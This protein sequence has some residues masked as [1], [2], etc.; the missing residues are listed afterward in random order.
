MTSFKQAQFGAWYGTEF[1]YFD[2]IAFK[3]DLEA[4]N[5]YTAA[6]N[7]FPLGYEYEYGYDSSSQPVGDSPYTAASSVRQGK[8]W[9]TKSARGK[10]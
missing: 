2:K 9:K 3:I 10:N 8:R 6:S 4:Q 1:Y 5:C 7:M